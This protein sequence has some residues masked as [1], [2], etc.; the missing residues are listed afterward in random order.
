MDS[1][2]HIETLTGPGFFAADIRSLNWD[3]ANSQLTAFAGQETTARLLNFSLDG[4]LISISSDWLGK[5]FH[6]FRTVDFGDQTYFLSADRLALMTP[7]TGNETSHSITMTD[8]LSGLAADRVQVMGL[9]LNT[10]NFLIAAAPGHGLAVFDWDTR[11]ETAIFTLDS[12]PQDIAGLAGFSGYGSQWVA[13]I[14]A[15]KNAV[16]LFRL[17]D[18]GTLTPTNSLGAEDGLGLNTPTA[19]RA[20]Q[21]DAQPYVIV[22]GAESNSLTVIRVEADGSLTPTDHILDSLDTRFSGVAQLE[23]LTIR[24]DTFVLAAGDDD[25]LSLFRI[26]PDGHLF[27][28]QTFADLDSVTL[29]NVAGLQMAAQG[30]DLHIFAASATEPGLTHLALSLA[31]LGEHLVGGSG[32]D[33]LIGTS[34]DDLLMGAAG[35]DQINGMAGDD[36]LSDGEGAD[37]LTGGGGHDTFLLTPDIQTDRITDFERGI[38]LIDL[39]R[40]PLLHDASAIGVQSTS[41]GAILT[42]RDDVL[43]IYSADGLS[44]DAAHLSLDQAFNLDRPPL[45]LADG[46]PPP[47]AGQYQVGTPGND[48]LTG[49]TLDDVLSGNAGDDLLIGG[50]GADALYGGY[51][52]DTASYRDAT[53]GVQADLHRPGGNTG[54]AD[55]DS[56]AGIEALEGSA[57]DDRLFSTNKAEVLRG[58]AG[59]D[60]LYGRRGDDSLFGGEGDDTLFGGDGADLLD[61]GPDFDTAS[62][63]GATGLRADLALPDRNTGEAAGDRYSEIEGL[64]GGTGTDRF[65]GDE[66]D[67][68]LWGLEGDDWLDGRG[69]D[70]ALYGGTGDDFLV[71]GNGADLLDGG[72][73]QDM[74]L[75][76]LAKF[77]VIIDLSTGLADGFA[78]GDILQS[79]EDLSGSPFDDSLAGDAGDNRLFGNAGDDILSGGAGSDTLSGGSGNDIMTGGAGGDTFLISASGGQDRITDFDPMEDQLFIDDALLT[80]ESGQTFDLITGMAMDPDAAVSFQFMSGDSLFLDDIE[81][82]DD[83]W[84]AIWFF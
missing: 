48:I 81:D 21:I 27:H 7:A 32:D 68:I 30:N 54:D 11:S 23:T 36:I 76:F 61:G 33:A 3:S 13:T 69:G 15:D 60:S 78:Q 37:R 74:A 8:G 34:L 77:P 24:A 63:P 47:P 22:A 64:S 82:P 58:L 44:L 5:S 20:F 56:Y 6:D 79:I 12:G 26:L 70:D 14:D 84:D 57:F 16:E 83:L 73:G 40:Y 72:G 46:D 71:G 43:E 53:A 41:W 35:N 42:L 65:F 28:V 19:L 51:G 18:T 29:D 25:G 75:Y 66:N 38:D 59:N 80:D 62:Y 39:S 10:Q 49:T 67:N 52:N 17:G 50:G 9:E 31:D 45:V 4:K 2:R 1:I 55:G